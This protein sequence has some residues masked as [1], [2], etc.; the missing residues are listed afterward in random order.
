MASETTWRTAWLRSKN[1]PLLFV[2]DVLGATPE[3][4]QAAALEA[5]GKHDRVSIRSGHGVGKTTLQAWL[6]LWFLLTRKN[7]KIP[8]A[9]NSQ[10]QL[11]DTIWPEIAKWHRRLP[12]ALRDMIEVQAERV[13]V[14][15]D[16]EGAFAVRRTASKEN[17]EALQGFHADHLL[18]L[19]DEASG[20]PDVVFEVGMGAL[21]TS[22]AKVVMAGNPTRAS[23]FFYD[24]H[25]SLRSRWHMMHVSCLDVPRAQGHIEDIKAKYGKGSNAWR[26]RV[27]GEFP[28]AD[29]ETVIPL[30]LVLSAVGRNI[31]S[32]DYYPV[33]GVD[34]A[35]F[36]DD[37]TALAK[38]QANKLLEPIRWWHSTDLM[39][40][41]GRIK[42]EYD[43]THYDS[44]PWAI[45][46][47]VIGLG[48]GVYDRCKELGLPVK[49]I[50]VGE[51]A[52]SRE[53]CMRLRDELWLKGREWFQQKACSIDQDEALIAELTAP[54][55]TFSSTGKMVVESKADMKKRGIRSPDLADAFLLTFAFGDRRKVERYRRP[56]PRNYSAWS[57]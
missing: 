38:R 49:A 33:W 56:E 2:T 35:R 31:S 16:P 44:R 14:A 1:Q 6:V 39:A 51:A 43:E 17:P 26:V 28:T 25:H 40:T 32:L 8:V 11:R 53:N 20:I 57:A 50:N 4:W 29:D 5:V 47:D 7:C 55:Y 46:I 48:A 34:V 24:T 27:L 15:Q 9:A 37:R 18:F 21:S 10:D 23:G 30:E 45:L 41:V 19:L 3:L 13:V 12:D 36:G 42:A 52:S 54:T 22:G